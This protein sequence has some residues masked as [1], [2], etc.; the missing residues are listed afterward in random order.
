MFLPLLLIP[1]MVEGTWI[2]QLRRAYVHVGLMLLLYPLGSIVTGCLLMGAY[3]YFKSRIVLAGVGVVSFLPWTCAVVY[4]MD[5]GWVKWTPFHSAMA[6]GMATLFGVT[7][8][9]GMYDE[10]EYRRFREW[11]RRVAKNRSKHRVRRNERA[12]VRADGGNLTSG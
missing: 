5:F 1:V 10:R 12:S 7:L 6:I 2:I 11:R 3:L 4:S 8:S 9:V